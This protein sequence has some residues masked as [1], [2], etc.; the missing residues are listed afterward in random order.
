MSTAIEA[1]YAM[2]GNAEWTRIG[3]QRG[4]RSLWALLALKDPDG[5]LTP[6]NIETIQLCAGREGDDAK[7]SIDRSTIEPA[8]WAN[9]VE[10][11]TAAIYAVECNDEI[12][13]RHES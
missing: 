4:R 7:V 13:Q 3:D 5:L 12:A 10:V 6:D 1:S 8:I 2:K 11:I 9:L